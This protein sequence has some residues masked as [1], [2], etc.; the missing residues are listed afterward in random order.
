Q[1]SDPSPPGLTATEIAAWKG[2]CG[3]L[4]LTATASKGSD[5][6]R[7]GQT[8]ANGTTD[9]A[10]HPWGS[11]GYEKANG[12]G[13]PRGYSHTY[14][15]SA[16]PDKVC[17]NFYDVH[18][19]GNPGTSNFQVPNATKEI[20]ADGDSGGDKDNSI[21][22]NAYDT[23]NGANC[24]SLNNTTK[25]TPIHN[26]SHSPVTV[27]PAGTTVHD[28]VTVSNGAATAPGG[29]VTFDWFTNNTCTGAPASTSSQFALANGQAEAASFAQG[30]LTPG[31]YSF[32]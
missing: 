10:G 23:T 5:A 6:D 19:G 12:A 17:V 7:T 18:G 4:P 28:T 20:T 2:G 9:C 14:L 8:C 27:V 15:K 25:T 3:R 1:F 16:L 26:S 24:I 29:N 30:P 11:W 21:Q 31:L 22:T 32:K 13:K